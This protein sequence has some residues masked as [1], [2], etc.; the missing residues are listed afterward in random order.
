[1]DFDNEAAGLSDRERLVNI[2]IKKGRGS[3]LRGWFRELDSR[4]NLE[5]SF[6]DFCEAAGRIGFHG[7]VYAVLGLDDDLQSLTLN[8]LFPEVDELFQRFRDWAQNTFGCSVETFNGLVHDFDASDNHHLNAEQFMSACRHHG[9][10]ASDDEIMDIFW[11]LDIEFSGELGQAEFIYLE[12]DKTA[13]YQARRAE[14]KKQSEKHLKMMAYVYDEDLK[15]GVPPTN[16]RAARPWLAQN[17]DN[18]PSLINRR[19]VEWQHTSYERSLEARIVFV[20]HLRTTF[21]NEVRAWRIGLDPEATFEIDMKVIS[22]Y[23]RKA[24][25]KLDTVALW[26]SLDKDYDGFF[27]LEELCI[28]NADILAS[29]QMWAFQEF[30]SCDAIWD[31]PEM[32]VARD[33]QARNSRLSSEKKLLFSS[34]NEV[35]KT[36]ECPLVVDTDMACVLLASLD[37]HGASRHETVPATI[38]TARLETRASSAAHRID[39]ARVSLMMLRK[40]RSCTPRIEPTC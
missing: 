3:F 1:M 29:F 23:C 2:L 21:G 37:K 39:I 10:E 28:R 36:C 13:R 38:K 6:H 22:R 4:G 33:R 11:G 32:A 7:D 15:R 20:R 9:F 16:R 14:R 34:F 31:C 12:K 25:L 5:V 27:R 40:D 8:E 17:F 19:R 26:R 35:L 30:G 18:L 24:D